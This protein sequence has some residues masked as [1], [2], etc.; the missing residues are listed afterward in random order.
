MI[1]KELEATLNMAFDEARKQRHEFITVEHLL[2]AL[3]DNASAAE[4]MSA[5][6]VNLDEL[7]VTL[8]AF[9]HDNTPQTAGSDELNTQPTLGFRRVIDR[10]QEIG[11][12]SCRERV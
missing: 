5:C 11:R 9:V 10:A 6:A 2:L 8:T 4:V 12:A 7:Y 3:L 1:S